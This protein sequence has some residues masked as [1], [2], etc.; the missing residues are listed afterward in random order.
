[1]VCKNKVDFIRAQDPFLCGLIGYAIS[2]LTARPFCISVHADYERM[3]QMDP[4]GAAP[5]F[6]GS[7]NLTRHL[8]KFLLARSDLVLAVSGYIAEYVKRCGAR[9]ERVRV[10]RHFIDPRFFDPPTETIRAEPPVVSVVSRLSRQKYI[11]DLPRI[12]VALAGMGVDFRIEV[13]GDG[14]ARREL[15][16]KIKDLELSDRIVLLGY[17]DRQG[18]ADLLGR[19]SACLVLC[20][21]ASLLETAAMSKPPVAYDW[22]WHSEIVET[23]NTGMLVPEGDTFGAAKALKYLLQNPELA[24][25]M[26]RQ[27]RERVT[28]M[29]QRDHL[30]E[31]RRAAYA[32]LIGLRSVDASTRV[33]SESTVREPQ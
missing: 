25:D 6:L 20:G 1:M 29:Y 10:F 26:G 9:P 11:L 2:L 3:N 17:Q 22:E 33:T 16:K 8:E 14:E 5:R 23:G 24:A 31:T 21:G 15:E 27:A 28:E 7:Y 18:V 13:A 19:S 32:E 4:G 30:L 12:A